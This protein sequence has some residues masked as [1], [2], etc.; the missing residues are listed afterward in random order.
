[1]GAMGK[2]RN[3]PGAGKIAGIS[4]GALAG[5]AGAVVLTGAVLSRVFATR[6]LSPSRTPH[7]PLRLIGVSDD[8]ASVTLP[9]TRETVLPGQFS[10][11]F[12]GGTGH[13]RVGAVLEVG[14]HWVRRSLVTVDRGE[15]S[16]GVSFGLG[17]AWYWHPRELGY[18]CVDTVIQ[19]PR[20]PAPAWYLPAKKDRG[21]FAIHVHGRGA[22]RR[23]TIRGI[24]PYAKAGYHNLVLSYRNDAE[25]HPGAS[26]RY[27]LGAEEWHDLDAAIDFAVGRGSREI[28]LIGWSMGGTI[29]LQAWRHSRFRGLIRGIQLD[30]PA[31]D[32]AE[33]LRHQAG[34]RSLPGPVVDSALGLI[35]SGRVSSGAEGGLD[36]AELNPENWAA[37]LTVPV[38]IQ[39][40]P[41]DTFVPDAAAV[42]FAAARPDLVTHRRIENAEHVR[43]WNR[44]PAGWEE[45]TSQWLRTLPPVTGWNTA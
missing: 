36:L 12:A 45:A 19:L 8:G 41:G 1:M 2:R 40:S 37:E 24:P 18:P 22:H 13:A 39:S 31:L 38:L 27:A 42:R 16:P 32:W 21:R 3:G 34:L 30:S 28:V 29:A 11:G 10:L 4:L 23:E 6:A 43:V 17:S 25:A 35:E 44:D 14:D 33:L 9:L 20:G 15:L 5:V 7:E 26:D